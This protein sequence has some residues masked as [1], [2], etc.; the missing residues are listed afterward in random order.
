MTDHVSV[1]TLGGSHEN[2]LQSTTV[3]IGSQVVASLVDY[4]WIFAAVS[5]HSLLAS[6]AYAVSWRS[7]VLCPIPHSL[8]RIKLPG[9][10]ADY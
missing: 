9:E 3:Y 7:G 10:L 2:R 8:E 4:S 5:L 6:H 1:Q